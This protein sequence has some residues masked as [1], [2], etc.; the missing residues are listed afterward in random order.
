MR[1]IDFEELD[2]A[3]GSYLENGVV[4]NSK[5]KNNEVFSKIE[6]QI[7]HSR[8]QQKM[9]FARKAPQSA[10]QLHQNN[11]KVQIRNFEK[12]IEKP[13][14]E[15][16]SVYKKPRVRI[17]DDFSAPVPPEHH[18]DNFGVSLL[19]REEKIAFESPILE[20]YGGEKPIRNIKKLENSPIRKKVVSKNE[21][22]QAR[23]ET[24]VQSQKNE[25]N[26]AEQK[27]TTPSRVEFYAGVYRIGDDSNKLRVFH[28]EHTVEIPERKVSSS[29]FENLNLENEPEKVM[30][31]ISSLKAGGNTITLDNYEEIKKDIDDKAKTEAS[32]IE[33]KT[34]QKNQSGQ[35]KENNKRID[36]FE[37]D[38]RVEE[39]SKQNEASEKVIIQPVDEIEKPK[40]PFV[41]N[42]QIEKRPLGTNQNQAKSF[43][44]KKPV[45]NYEQ[46]SATITKELRRAKMSAPI[47]SSD[48]YSAPIKHKKKSGWGVV[49]AIIAILMLGAGA[50]LVAYLVAFR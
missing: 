29:N 39:N 36:I 30:P 50:G 10:N 25:I 12:V 43:E 41:Q 44:F 27:T 9:V 18:R 17:L 5:E 14:N 42:P 32:K 26:I 28:G 40:T 49:L 8:E 37:A 7:E 19:A 48:E 16:K 2:K 22:T 4:P 38:E 6:S 46:K 3:V 13:K 15:K 20:T 31:E 45:S 23:K 1:D 35:N 34:E 47:L 24:E 21:K 33:V 11:E